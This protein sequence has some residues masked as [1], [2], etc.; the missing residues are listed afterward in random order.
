MLR[1]RQSAIGLFVH[2]AVHAAAKH[3]ERTGRW[4]EVD[5]DLPDPPCFSGLSGAELFDVVVG[6]TTFGDAAPADANASGVEIEIQVLEPMFRYGKIVDSARQNVQK[7][8]CRGVFLFAGIALVDEVLR[9]AQI[10]VVVCPDLQGVRCGLSCRIRR[11]LAH[12]TGLRNDG[13]L[14]VRHDAL[15][16]KRAAEVVQTLEV[17]VERLVAVSK[18]ACQ[19]DEDSAMFR[20]LAPKLQ[21]HG[22]HGRVSIVAGGLGIERVRPLLLGQTLAAGHVLTRLQEMVVVRARRS[23]NTARHHGTAIP[24]PG[25]SGELLAGRRFPASIPMQRTAALGDDRIQLADFALQAIE[26]TAVRQPEHSAEAQPALARPQKAAP[27]LSKHIRSQLPRHGVLGAADHIGR[28]GQQLVGAEGRHVVHAVQIDDD[29]EVPAVREPIDRRHELLRL[30]SVAY[31]EIDDHRL[32]V[33][34]E[35]G[36]PLRDCPLQRPCDAICEVAAENA[37]D[38]GVAALVRRVRVPFVRRRT[39][40]EAREGLYSKTGPLPPVGGLVGW[41]QIFRAKR[42]SGTVESA[43]GDPIPNIRHRFDGE[44]AQRQCKADLERSASANDVQDVAEQPLGRLL[45]GAHDT[46]RFSPARSA[47]C[48]RRLGLPSARP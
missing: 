17:L 34:G 20:H 33:D 47:S 11:R 6:Q 26:A 19:V 36:E 13:G 21:E 32:G 5:L 31:G 2:Q 25:G 29:V 43:K 22:I 1:V 37:N 10:D 3:L 39:G 44:C 12:G 7:E 9:A 48:S 16:E 38:D 27:L 8:L 15:R 41:R 23:R 30:T 46:S 45:R 42:H 4:A 24:E 18:R 28:Q 35:L 40:G 14:Y